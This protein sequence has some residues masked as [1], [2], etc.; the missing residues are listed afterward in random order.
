[1]YYAAIG[2]PKDRAQTAEAHAPA[3][4][5]PAAYHLEDYYRH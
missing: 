4:E 3:P 1:M 2:G 5:S